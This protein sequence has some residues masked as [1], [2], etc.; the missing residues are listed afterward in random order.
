M[1]LLEP[2]TE[3]VAVFHGLKSSD[4]K[5]A[6]ALFRTKQDYSSM[7][8]FKVH[9]YY[10]TGTSCKENFQTGFVVAGGGFLSY[11]NHQLIKFEEEKRFGL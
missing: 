6:F 4:A 7:E 8:S 10:G 5:K 2:G 9:S 3:Y 11:W 1:I